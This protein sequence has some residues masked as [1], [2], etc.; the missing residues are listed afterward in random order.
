MT[1]SGTT[2]QTLMWFKCQF[3]TVAIF[4]VCDKTTLRNFS[5]QKGYYLQKA[6][7][8]FKNLTLKDN[9]PSIP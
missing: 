1:A 2:R 7:V 4:L 3:K 5:A 8:K 9:W 6:P